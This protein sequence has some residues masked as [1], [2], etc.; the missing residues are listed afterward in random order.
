MGEA[1]VMFLFL[2][3]FLFVFCAA[4]CRMYLVSGVISAASTLGSKPFQSVLLS[5]EDIYFLSNC[6]ELSTIWRFCHNPSVVHVSVAAV[7]TVNCSPVVHP[8]H[9]RQ[10]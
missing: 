2:F 6:C 5:P 9:R 7:A 10:H 4:I 3:L 8:C 1:C